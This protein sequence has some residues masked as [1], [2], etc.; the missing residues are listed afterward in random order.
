MGKVRRV[1]YYPDEFIV[2]TSN[3]TGEEKGCYWTVC[4]LIYSHGEP[5]EDDAPWIAKVCGVSTRR[6]GVIRER[7]LSIGKLYLEGGRLANG[8]CETELA[9]DGARP[10]QDEWRELRRSVFERDDYTCQYCG[11]RG[12]ALECDHV[13]PAW[14]GGQAVPE[15]LVTACRPCNRAKGGRTPE[16]WGRS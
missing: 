6:W 11:K 12:G 13:I 7:L 4:S 3:L 2:G 10:P 9:K 15:N 16:Q 1:D 5:I 8:R 14:M